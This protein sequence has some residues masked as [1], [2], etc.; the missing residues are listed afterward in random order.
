MNANF[1]MLRP[2]LGRPLMNR[3]SDTQVL[4]ILMF[5]FSVSH[6]TLAFF[7]ADELK[8]INYEIDIL[9]LPVKRGQEIELP[10]LH[11]TSKFGQ[12]Y[13]CQLP[14][15]ITKDENKES[16]QSGDPTIPDIKELLQPLKSLPCLLKTKDW[17]TYEF[18][19]G[20]YIKQ[21]HIEDGQISGVVMTLGQFD[22]DYEWKTKQE[23]QGESSKLEQNRYH[24][25]FYVNG[26]KCDLTSHS[27]ASE[28]RFFCEPDAGDYIHRVDEPE[29]CRYIITIHKKCTCD[30]VVIPQAD[31]RVKAKAREF[32]PLCECHYQTRKITTIR[33]VVI[34]IIWVI[35]LLV[36]Y[37]LF[38]MCL[39]PLM[40]KKRGPYQE[41]TNEEVN[42]DEPLPTVTRPRASS[43]NVL[44][45]VGLQQDKWK[46]QVQEQRR[47]IYD[48]HTMLN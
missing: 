41:Q 24:S 30:E 48:R 26:S 27:R 36:V 46:R 22:S 10:V 44:N 13:Q 17:W 38:L 15:P 31:E 4:L 33:V 35:S 25:Q 7:N 16:N 1:R 45:R 28:V 18:C 11:M 43:T 19:Y 2:G 5:V 12:P 34:L 29:T 23:E 21:Y 8:F 14:E 40:N 3:R 20:R 39:D 42:L 37:M 9:N 6:L 47:N 32:C